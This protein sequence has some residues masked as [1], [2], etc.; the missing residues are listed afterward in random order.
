MGMGGEGGG[1]A[2]RPPLLGKL[3]MLELLIKTFQSSSE[4]IDLQ[5]LAF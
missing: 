4:Q 2:P 5:S 1:H 3:C